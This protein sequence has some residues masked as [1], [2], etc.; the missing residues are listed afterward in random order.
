ME[1]SQIKVGLPHDKQ[2]HYQNQKIFFK[3]QNIFLLQT[4]K[5]AESFG[6]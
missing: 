3:T 4:R 6:V 5:L 2:K 1:Q